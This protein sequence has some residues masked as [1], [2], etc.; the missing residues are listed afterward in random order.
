MVPDAAAAAALLLL[1]AA[2]AITVPPPTDVTVS[3]QNVNTTV[4]WKHAEETETRFQVTLKGADPRT[5][6]IETL[7]RELDLTRFL[8]DS[9]DSCMDNYYVEVTALWDGTQSAAVRS[10]SFSFNSLKPP[11]LMCLLDFPPVELTVGESGAMVSFQNPLRFYEEL[12]RVTRQDV[13]ASF[14]YSVA[15]QRKQFN[16]SCSKDELVCRRD[17]VFSEGEE[18]FVTLSGRF[19]KRDC[20]GEVVFRTT[21][22]IF[23]NDLTSSGF[24]R[25]ALIL[26]VSLASMLGVFLLVVAAVTVAICKV[27]GWTM[28]KTDPQTPRVL[29][30]ADEGKPMVLPHFPHGG[31]VEPVRALIPDCPTE[32]EESKDDDLGPCSKASISSE[33][34]YQDGGLSEDSNQGSGSGPSGTSASEW[35]ECVSVSSEEDKCAG[36]Y[37]RQHRLLDVGDGDMVMSYG[38]R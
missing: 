10:I 13:G 31:T 36:G 37:D 11:R 23:Q 6:V 14:T 12:K 26:T 33:E 29:V 15:T 20:L 17:V 34:G 25:D 18:R 30:F 24:D 28:D 27:R 35:T 21:E 4:S 9:M 3:C 1:C 22:P 7:A 8:W 5:L 19:C 16:A 38:N 2:S 32:T